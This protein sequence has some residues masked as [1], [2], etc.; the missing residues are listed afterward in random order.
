MNCV[1]CGKPTV[2]ELETCS[3]DC[4]FKLLKIQG[5]KVVLEEMDLREGFLYPITEFLEKVKQLYPGRN[6]VSN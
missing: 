1:I 6:P 5:K 4:H 3:I 2:N